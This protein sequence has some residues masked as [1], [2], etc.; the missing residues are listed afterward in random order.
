[1]VQNL[2]I[3]WRIRV[4]QKRPLLVAPIARAPER[5]RRGLPVGQHSTTD[6]AVAVYGLFVGVDNG[7]RMVPDLNPSTSLRRLSKRTGRAHVRDPTR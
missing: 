6:D 4:L 5:G 1:M 3:L 7:D 2:S